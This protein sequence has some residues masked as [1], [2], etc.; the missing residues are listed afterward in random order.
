[1]KTSQVLEHDHAE[2]DQSK[3]SDKIEKAQ[4]SCKKARDMVGKSDPSLLV[5]PLLAPKRL[6][7]H[8]IM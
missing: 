8:A 4:K 7:V 3:L 2:R 6:T 1:M 5:H